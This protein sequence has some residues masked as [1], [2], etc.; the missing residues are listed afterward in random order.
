MLPAWLD[1]RLVSALHCP[2]S[3]HIESKSEWE[4]RSSSHIAAQLDLPCVLS[5][6]P[7]IEAKLFATIKLMTLEQL[8]TGIA[9]LLLDAEQQVTTLL[10]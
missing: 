2:R 9:V 7:D 5:G 8:G 3:V 1:G 6:T 4:S 10:N